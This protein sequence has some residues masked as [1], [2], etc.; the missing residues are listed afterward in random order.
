MV[1]KTNRPLVQLHARLDSS[2]AN[3]GQSPCVAIPSPCRCIQCCLPRLVRPVDLGPEVEQQLH[4]S[5]MPCGVKRLG[6]R[7]EAVQVCKSVPLEKPGSANI[8]QGNEQYVG[9]IKTPWR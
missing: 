6:V 8:Q 5:E 7:H 9:S 2:V 4:S 1:S 3:G